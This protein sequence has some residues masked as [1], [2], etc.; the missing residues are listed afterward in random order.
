MG[1]DPV[2]NTMWVCICNQVSDRTIKKMAL[3]GSDVSQIMLE[4]KCGMTCGQCYMT[5]LEVVENARNPGNQGVLGG[6][7]VVV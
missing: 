3:D 5:L 7:P 4:T 1:S 2:L 6:L